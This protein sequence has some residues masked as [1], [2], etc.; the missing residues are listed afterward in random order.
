MRLLRSPFT[1]SR[2]SASDPADAGRR[3]A[4]GLTGALSRTLRR[5]GFDLCTTVTGCSQT[6]R[7]SALAIRRDHGELYGPVAS[8]PNV[9]AGTG[10]DW[11]RRPEPGRHRA[12]AAACAEADRGPARVHPGLAGGRAGTWIARV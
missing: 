10:R 5:R 9:V 12:G 11:P 7:V 4:K 8:D 6:Q 1:W 2:S 3:D